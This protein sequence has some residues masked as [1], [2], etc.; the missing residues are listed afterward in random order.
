MEHTASQP[1]VQAGR[2]LYL[3]CLRILATFAVMI[4]HISAG[5]WH[6]SDPHGLTWQC[7]NLY[8]SL[9]RWCV[10]VFVMISGA[11]FLERNQSLSRLYRKN[12]LRIVTAFLFWSAAYVLVSALNGEHTA[13]ELLIAFL[14][15]HYHMWFLFMIAGIYM[16]I[17]LVQKITASK[18]LTKYFLLLWLVFSVLLP[19]V[20]SLLSLKFDTAAALLSSVRSNTEFHFTVGY[21]GYFVAGYY[22]NK[23]ELSISWR[24][25][26]YAIG[27][28]GFA[29]TV[30]LSSL[31]SLWKN[32][33]SQMFYGYFSL[34]VLLEALF[35]FVLGKY[36]F[37]IIRFSKRVERLITTL[38]QYSF[39]AYL[40]HAMVIEQLAHLLHFSAL[41]FSPIISVPIVG[42]VVFPVSFGISALIHKLLPHLSKYIA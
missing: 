27:V 16:I 6:G 25:L 37:G 7:F 39:G 2:V 3:D 1:T 22:F 19:Q 24:R 35:V 12:I 33:P 11:L 30:V 28:C 26:I 20:T 38:S 4:L 13:G 8:N 31:I 23:T 15:G 32:E 34:N 42:C 5:Y 10:P 29:G 41:S 21:V 40:V 17:P 36:L 14:T 18:N 9:S